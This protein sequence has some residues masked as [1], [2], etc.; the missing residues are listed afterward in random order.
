MKKFCETHLIKLRTSDAYTPQ[1]N[2]LAERF[3]QTILKSVRSILEDSG[4]DRKW[5]HKVVKSSTL[6]LNQIPSHQLSKSPFELFKNRSLSLDYFY[7][8]GNKVLYVIQPDQKL[9]KLAPQ[10]KISL[11]IGYN[12]EISSWKILTQEDKILDTKHVQFLEFSSKKA[13]G[14]LSIDAEEDTQESKVDPD[15]V[16]LELDPGG[17]AD[18]VKI[19]IDTISIASTDDDE[20]VAESLVP[21]PAPSQI[22]RDRNSKFKPFKYTY[23]TT[24]PTSFKKTIKCRDGKMWRLLLTRR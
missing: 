3:N 18:S 9:S 21:A 24:H 8:I 15:E 2:G 11:L 6:A 7:P 5:W 16:A 19:E 12:D 10:G 20:E 4:I 22:L 13:D 23:L 1:Q 17:D 14:K